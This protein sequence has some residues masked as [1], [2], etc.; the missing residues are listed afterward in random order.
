[1]V[2]VKVAGTAQRITAGA[3][4]LFQ[5]DGANLAD[6][7][8]EGRE[9][10][11]QLARQISQTLGNIRV[12]G[13]ADRIGTPGYNRKLSEARAKTVSPLLASEGLPAA[14]SACGGGGGRA[15][16]HE[17]ELLQ[18]EGP[19]VWLEAGPSTGSAQTGFTVRTGS[20]DSAL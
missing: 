10:I 15:A 9:K 13:H 12:I 17:R 4:G 16:S 8:P 20:I 7:L 11:M 2:A 5:F 19:S 18:S 14:G 6:M 3:D 1:M